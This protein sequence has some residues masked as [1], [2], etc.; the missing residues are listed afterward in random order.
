MYWS[1]F[2]HQSVLTT[3]HIKAV[4]YNILRIQ[5]FVGT[6]RALD[7]TLFNGWVSRVRIILISIISSKLIRSWRSDILSADDISCK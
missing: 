5:I 2:S 1:F 4:I 7:F 3:D 6:P